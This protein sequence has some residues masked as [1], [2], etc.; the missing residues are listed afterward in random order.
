MVGSVKSVIGDADQNC[1]S[2]GAGMLKAIIG[3]GIIAALIAF[4]VQQIADRQTQ[5][6]PTVVTIQM[7]TPGGQGG[8]G[9]GGGI[10]IP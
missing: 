6:G 2:E 10:V 3:L 7:P 8:G 1:D 5:R 4:G 9:G